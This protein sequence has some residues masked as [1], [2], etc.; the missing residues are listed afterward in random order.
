MEQRR[1]V[2]T[3]S[4]SIFREF[5]YNQIVPQGHFLRKVKQIIDW[6]RF[7]RGMLSPPPRKLIKLYIG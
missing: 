6:Q 2:E 1:Y 4:S 3:G 7:S 5:L